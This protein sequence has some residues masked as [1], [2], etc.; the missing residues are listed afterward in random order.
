M[1]LQMSRPV[2]KFAVL[3]LG[4]IMPSTRWGTFFDEPDGAV[5]AITGFLTDTDS[6]RDMFGC[7]LI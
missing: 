1:K 5:P 2:L 6:R 7:D 4:T 3:K